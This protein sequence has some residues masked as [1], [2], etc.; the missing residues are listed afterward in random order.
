MKSTSRASL[1]LITRERRA[2]VCAKRICVNPIPEDAQGPSSLEIYA[3]AAFERA[4]VLLAGQALQLR[5]IGTVP[6]CTRT[7][8]ET[9][10]QLLLR[11][12]GALADVPDV[13]HVAYAAGRQIQIDIL[14][15]C[16]RAPELLLAAPELR[17]SAEGGSVAQST[18]YLW[19]QPPL[20]VARYQD[21]S[22]LI[23]LDARR[24]RAIVQYPSVRQAPSY[25][26]AAPMRDLVHWLHVLDGRY[27]LHGAAVG[28][29][30]GGVL[31]V[32]PGG[33]GKSTAATTALQR[34]LSFAGD[35][36]VALDVEARRA[37]GV[38]RSVKVL[39]H[40]THR[41]T[42]LRAHPFVGTPETGAKAV[43]FLDVEPS[44]FCQGIPLRAIVIPRIGGA[45]RASTALTAL[46]SCTPAQAVAAMAPST[47]FQTMGYRSEV[48]N[49]CRALALSLPAFEWRPG[50]LDEQYA[51]RLLHA[52]TRIIATEGSA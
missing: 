5:L 19:W 11:A 9:A 28:T 51:D 37:F 33:S 10:D 29:E 21:S 27:L 13:A 45:G 52:L 6:V 46:T 17:L 2:L 32:G 23:V 26:H 16:N 25:E 7:A 41:Y 36:Y 48:F 31:L 40:D 35:D 44:G 38:F 43:L 49:A 18:R 22:I 1:G 4:D 15:G 14:D 8:S 50:P 42:G 12:F 3:D 39:P 24:R 20:H 47:L 34:G 30:R